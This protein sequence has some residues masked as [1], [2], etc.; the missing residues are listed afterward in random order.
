VVYTNFT[1]LVA[2]AIAW[3]TLGETPSL[4]QLLGASGVVAGSI[5]VRAGKIERT[6]PEP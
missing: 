4:L 3:P 6:P 5:L 1:P 2:L